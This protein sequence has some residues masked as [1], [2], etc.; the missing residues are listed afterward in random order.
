MFK[1][2][3]TLN[4]LQIHPVLLLIP[5]RTFALTCLNTFV[6]FKNHRHTPIL[7][8]NLVLLSHERTTY[9]RYRNGWRRCTAYLPSRCSHTKGGFHQ[10]KTIETYPS[11]T[12]RIDYIRTIVYRS[13]CRA[14]PRCQCVLLLRWS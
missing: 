5:Q 14:A 6:H 13:A 4:F 2:F 10:Q 3:I 1:C 12:H 7:P 9:G 8:T 11:Q